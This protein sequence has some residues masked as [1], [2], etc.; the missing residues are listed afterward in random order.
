MTVEIIVQTHK[1][2]VLLEYVID[3]RPLHGTHFAVF[4]VQLYLVPNTVFGHRNVGVTLLGKVIDE[5]VAVCKLQIIFETIHQTQAND[6][7]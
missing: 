7:F 2:A 6:A 4:V 5:G 3:I 1:K